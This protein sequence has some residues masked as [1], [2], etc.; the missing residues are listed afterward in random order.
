ML[1]EGLCLILA[2]IMVCLH[3]V[4][5]LSASY[6]LC[7][8][9]LNMVMLLS[10]ISNHKAISGSCAISSGSEAVSISNAICHKES[11]MHKQCDMP[12]ALSKAINT[13][14]LQD[15]ESKDAYNNVRLQPR[16]LK[17]SGNLCFMN[18][19]LQVCIP[20]LYAILALSASLLG[21]CLHAIYVLVQ[22]LPAAYLTQACFAVHFP[23]I[24]FICAAAPTVTGSDSAPCMHQLLT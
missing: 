21:C 19:T 2:C 13:W 23:R 9:C 16:G 11:N 7:A 1:A 12:Q 17:N 5:T 18:A 15:G 20:Q 6:M 3:P 8:N 24:G 22:V 14:L 4:C 10:A